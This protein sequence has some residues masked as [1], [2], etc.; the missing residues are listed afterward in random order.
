MGAPGAERPEHDAERPRAHVRATDDARQ[1]GDPDS[2]QNGMPDAEQMVHHSRRSGSPE[3]FLLPSFSGSSRSHPMLDP[4]FFKNR[5]FS[6]SSLTITVA[7][8][9]IFGM[10]FVI[11]QYFQFEARSGGDA[12]ED[13]SASRHSSGSTSSTGPPVASKLAVSRSSDPDVEMSVA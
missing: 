7:F 4:R 11:T 1:H 12:G 3:F 6:L 5:A 8:F 2:G 13:A 10:F 9:G